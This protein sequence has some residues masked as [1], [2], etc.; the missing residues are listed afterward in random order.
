[1]DNNLPIPLAPEAVAA[2][3][4]WKAA[5]TRLSRLRRFWG[6]RQPGFINE[7][8]RMRYPT[9][10]SGNTSVSR[11]LDLAAILTKRSRGPRED[12]VGTQLQTRSN[13]ITCGDD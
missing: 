6:W 4:T 1:M 8:E 12:T 5:C 2:M 11:F 10:S 9:I 7:P 3:G 13:A